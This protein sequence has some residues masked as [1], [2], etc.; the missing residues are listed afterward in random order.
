MAGGA[1]SKPDCVT[2]AEPGGSFAVG[3]SVPGGGHSVRNC[4]FK[5]FHKT[6]IE[7]EVA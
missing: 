7:F 2:F 3:V 6:R 5:K 4:D 1:P